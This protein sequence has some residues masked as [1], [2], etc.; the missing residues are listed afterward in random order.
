MNMKH[1]ICAAA[2]AMAAMPA[3][4]E[5]TA[6][7]PDHY[8]LH[9]EAVSALSPEDM[10]D[11]L[12]QPDIWWHPDHSWS[13]DAANLSLTPEAGGLWRED[14]DGGSVSHGVVLGVIEGKSLTLDAPFGP[15]QSMAVNVVWTISI[16]AEAGG[17]RVIFDET[18]NGSSASGLDQIAT[19]VDGVKAEAIR[20]LT[21]S[22]E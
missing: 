1:T 15:L 17:S 11:R 22:G 2:L 16:E 12:L 8:T 5:I 4:A 10:W 6:S 3:A 18:A 19:A 7:A 21:M 13:G 9:H 14:W 20:R